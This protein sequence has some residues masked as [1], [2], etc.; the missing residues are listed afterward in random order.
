MTSVNLPFAATGDRRAPTSGELAAGFECGP[1]DIKLFNWFAYWTTGN[2]AEIIRDAGL[3]PDDASYAQ[4]AIAV[5]SFAANSFTAGGTA[6]ALTG[7]LTRAIS[8]YSDITGVPLLVKIGSSSNTGAATLNLHSLGAK[9]ILR[10]DG[11]ALQP[12]DIPAATY[13]PVIYD[14]TA[15]RNLIAGGPNSQ[16]SGQQ[17]WL[18]AGTYSWTVPN[19]VYRIFIQV[20]G[21]GGGGGGA[22]YTSAAA[23][24][25]GGGAG[26]TAWKI[27]TVEPGDSVAIVVGAG[28][29]FGAGIGGGSGGTGGTS[30]V[31]GTVIAGG[32]AGGIGAVDSLAGTVAAGGTASGGDV[33][34]AGASSASAIS[35]PTG[36]PV[37]GCGGRP[38]L[39]SGSASGNQGTIGSAGPYPGCGGNGASSTSGPKAG[40]VGAAGCVIITY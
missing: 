29:T 13:I 19:G 27:L 26:A 31:A 6:N 25:A 35:I 2:I 10:M 12:G 24:G 34:W 15:F 11:A 23:A 33:N 18:T 5:R 4:A 37:S 20:Y 28:G 17:V 9:S 22:Q 38:I 14:G 8:A 40:G 21:A 32:G 16:T 3:T 7:S 39:F 36:Q 30:S 1:A